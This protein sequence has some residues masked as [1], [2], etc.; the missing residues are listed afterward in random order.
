M[1][2]PAT[3]KRRVRRRR[4][5]EE[6][7]EEA[8]VSA[9]RL[10]LEHGQDAVTLKAV[11]EDLGMTHTN[12]LHHFG[13]AADLQAALMDTMARDLSA[14]LLDAVRELRGSQAKPAQ[15]QVLVDKV[16]DAFGRG[17][18]G[19]LAVWLALTGKFA[20]L[21]QVED[22]LNGLVDAI[23]ET[24]AQ[25]GGEAHRAVTSALLVLIFCAFADST[26]GSVFAELLGRE[27]TAARKAVARILPRMF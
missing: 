6:A 10:L 15:I 16:F 24:F 9:R 20:Q 25:K 4:L 8:I 7:R 3:H 1:S 18:A 21:E 13:S 17:G 14:A 27:R 22:A 2:L 23:E 19:R 26:I 11:A 5:P 12:L